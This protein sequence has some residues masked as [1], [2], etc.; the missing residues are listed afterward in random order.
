MLRKSH[1]FDTEV[2][3]TEYMHPDAS[4]VEALL[5]T[6]YYKTT[7][8]GGGVGGGGTVTKFV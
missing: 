1:D 4:L 2:V 3:L 5:G 8:G 7:G 6:H